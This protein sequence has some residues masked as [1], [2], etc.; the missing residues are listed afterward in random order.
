M[1]ILSDS[2]ASILGKVPARDVDP[3]E[4]MRDAPNRAD[5][6]RTGLRQ[7]VTGSPTTRIEDEAGDLVPSTAAART[8][9]RMGPRVTLSRVTRHSGELHP[10]AQPD[11][12]DDRD[13]IAVARRKVSEKRL[14]RAWDRQ[15][16]IPEKERP[17]WVYPW[18][19]QAWRDLRAARKRARAARR[20]ARSR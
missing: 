6:R 10:L 9:K 16:A 8:G 7:P 14:Q 17:E 1:S 12:Y 20:A 11:N 4:E 3:A 18:A 5:R 19:E 15:Q 2:I 13:P